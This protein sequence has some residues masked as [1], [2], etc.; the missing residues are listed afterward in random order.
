MAIDRLEAL[1]DFHSEDPTDPFT[2]FA[3]AQEYAKRGLTDDALGFYESLVQDAPNYVGTYYHLGKLYE[4]LG[5]NEE[6]RATYRNGM[7]VAQQQSD[8]H[9][10]AELNDALLALE[11]LG[12]DDI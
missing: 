7:N 2:R 1:L 6:A 3:I 4:R 12:W 8:F 5:R 10:R 9:A 11:G